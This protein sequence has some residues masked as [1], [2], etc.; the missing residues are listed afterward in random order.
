MG[1]LP[2]LPDNFEIHLAKTVRHVTDR[3]IAVFTTFQNVH[4][5]SLDADYYS[6]N[7]L[8]SNQ[9]ILLIHYKAPATYYFKNVRH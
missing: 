7:Y 1:P 3:R 6:Y 8:A 4:G 2:Y 5:T 9:P